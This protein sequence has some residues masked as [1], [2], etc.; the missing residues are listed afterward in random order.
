MACSKNSYLHPNPGFG[1]WLN[2][3]VYIM[4]TVPSRLAW[5]DRFKTSGT[6]FK[7][8]T[9]ST[10][11]LFPEERSLRKLPSKQRRQKNIFQL[12]KW[13]FYTREDFRGETHRMACAMSHVVLVSQS[14]CWVNDHGGKI[15]AACLLTPAGRCSLSQTKFSRPFKAKWAL[16][17]RA[18]FGVCHLMI[19]ADHWNPESNELIL[20]RWLSNFKK[21]RRNFKYKEATHERQQRS[22]LS[23]LIF[24]IAASH[25]IAIKRSSLSRRDRHA[26][27]HAISSSWLV[28]DMQKFTIEPL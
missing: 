18:I 12:L 3:S 28:F 17:L 25:L 21:S 6:Q 13:I 2:I 20:S 1:V 11:H 15:P 24:K 23:S 27:T 5:R 10:E 26:N 4:Q 14:S 22:C 9:I 8:I 16:I 7:L 19:I